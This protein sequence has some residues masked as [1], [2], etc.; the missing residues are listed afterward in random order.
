M[1]LNELVLAHLAD[2]EHK[3]P[4][5]VDAADHGLIR[6]DDGAA[7]GLPVKQCRETHDGSREASVDNA[8]A[9]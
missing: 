7:A 8:N 9:E 6:A 3:A 2:L 4:L 1:T 5:A